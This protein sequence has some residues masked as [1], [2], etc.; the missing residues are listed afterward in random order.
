M[1]LNFGE[2]GEEQLSF[3]QTTTTTITITVRDLDTNKATVLDAI[4]A[5]L[6]RQCN[7]GNHSL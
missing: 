2:M 1:G 7:R 6:L 4:P 5:Q 3:T